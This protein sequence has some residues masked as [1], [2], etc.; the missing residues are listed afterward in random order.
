[1]KQLYFS[2]VVVAVVAFAAAVALAQKEAQAAITGKD[3]PASD[4]M[5]A[6]DAGKSDGADTK[7]V[8]PAWVVSST[9][10][11]A[12]AEAGDGGTMEEIANGYF[13]LAS[14]SNKESTDDERMA[15]IQEAAKWMQ[16]RAKVIVKA[17]EMLARAEKGDEAAMMDLASSFL[18]LAAARTME[19]KG[20]ER[21]AKFQKAMVWLR[22]RTEKAV[23]S[24]D[25]DA[26][27]K[28]ANEITSTLSST[29]FNLN[30]E[31]QG[32]L[33]RAMERLNRRCNKIVADREGDVESVRKRAEAGD[34]AAQRAL[35]FRYSHGV[36]VGKD[37]QKGLKWTRKAVEQGDA[38]AML[39]L[40][41]AYVDGEGVT[42]DAAKAIALY[43]K[44]AKVFLDLAKN[45]EKLDLRL[46]RHAGQKLVYDESLSVPDVGMTFLGIAAKCG[47]V[48]AMRTYGAQ[49]VFGEY[50]KKDH[51]KGL[52]WLQKAVLHGDESASAWIWLAHQRESD[53]LLLELLDKAEAGDKE[54]AA[55]VDDCM[56]LLTGDRP[57]GRIESNA[58]AG[59]APSQAQLG[60]AY[61]LGRSVEQDKAKAVKWLRKAVDQGEYRAMLWL[62]TAY[63]HGQG[64]AKDDWRAFDLWRRSHELGWDPATEK[65]HSL[66]DEYRKEAEKG[67]ASAQFFMGVVHE[68]GYAGKPDAAKAVEWYRKSAEQ[69][70]SGAM[71]NLGT[72]Y[73]EGTGVKRDIAEATKWF[74][75]AASLGHERSAKILEKLQKE[76][77]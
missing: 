38:R 76:A 71:F 50:V 26:I 32:A 14:S 51:N 75:R 16:R 72:C 30:E 47:D 22:R 35:G 4:A 40:A 27:E 17:P 65:L 41:N 58:L 9:G 33:G 13:G 2:R 3:N 20:E 70:H 68:Y 67:N 29:E 31:E 12:R 6:A 5:R 42:K 11:V 63:E 7:D 59:H 46:L 74:K 39:D 64:V 44:A 21:R 15:M 45:G 36:D 34:P 57:L 77:V 73:L 1:M 60:L 53:R 24:D 61:M 43:R 18:F 62:G 23:T 10:T 56:K 49:F 66:S 28:V 25:A 54:A 69:G 48:E 37:L 55:R 19:A 52:L 8:P